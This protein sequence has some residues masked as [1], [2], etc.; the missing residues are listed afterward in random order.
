M[1]SKEKI[2]ADLCE[3][4]TGWI[5]SN[6]NGSIKIGT[7][8]EAM[9]IHARNCVIEYHKWYVRENDTEE[10]ERVVDGFLSSDYFKEI[11]EP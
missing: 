6:P 7:V 1:E 2:I 11:Q 3:T 8:T 4:T 5:Q 10:A 9:Q